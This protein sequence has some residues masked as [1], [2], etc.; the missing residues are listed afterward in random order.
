MEFHYI[1]IIVIT[2]MMQVL[3][4]MVKIIVECGG[5]LMMNDGL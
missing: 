4:E 5:E 1:L 3:L 2:Q